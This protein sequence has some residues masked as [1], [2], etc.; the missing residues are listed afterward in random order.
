MT[1]DL[2]SIHSPILMVMQSK[3]LRRFGFPTNIKSTQGFK[4]EY[5]VCSNLIEHSY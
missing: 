2:R 4:R 1:G 3:A 5:M